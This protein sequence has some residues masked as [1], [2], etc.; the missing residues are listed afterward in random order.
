MEKL[1]V[2]DEKFYGRLK[3][4]SLTSRQENLFKTLMNE[5]S[6]N[7]FEDIK[8][9]NY[10]SVFLEIGFGNGEHIAKMAL[11]HPDSLFIG[12]EPFVNGVASLLTKIDDDKIENI[13]IYQADARNLIKDMPDNFLSGAFLLFP[14]PW[15]KRKHIRRRFLQDKTI[16][17]IYNKLKSGA[18]WKIASDHKE[19][20]AWILKLFNQEK[21]KKCF[22]GEIFNRKS[23]PDEEFWPKTRYEQKAVDEILYAIYTKSDSDLA[24]ELNVNH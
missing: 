8:N 23:R 14:D 18:S 11:N 6:I 24:P 22:H 20:R 16:S 2:I 9:L 15:P 3:S 12:C 21:F 4:R 19:Y 17:D 1:T 10:D 7:S 5:I 13:Q